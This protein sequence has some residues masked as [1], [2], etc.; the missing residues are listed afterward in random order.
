MSNTSDVTIKF[1]IFVF[2]HTLHK[3]FV[4]VFFLTFL[5]PGKETYMTL[6]RYTKKRNEEILPLIR[7]L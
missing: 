6:L 5:Q 7:A 3:T 4:V 1:S 2:L